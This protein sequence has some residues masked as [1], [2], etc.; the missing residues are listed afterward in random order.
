MSFLWLLKQIPIHLA[1]Y[2]NTRLFSDSSGGQNLEMSFM[3]L[4]SKCQHVWFLLRLP[5]PF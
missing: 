3:E 2:S 1:A 5:G 4:K